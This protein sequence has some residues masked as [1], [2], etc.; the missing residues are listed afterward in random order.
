[1][2]SDENL[3]NDSCLWNFVPSSPVTSSAHSQLLS[4][5]Q[6]LSS[7][8]IQLSSHRLPTP[9]ECIK[10]AEAADS[11][12][13]KTRCEVLEVVASIGLRFTN[14]EIFASAYN[15]IFTE[16]CLHKSGGRCQPCAE[17]FLIDLVKALELNTTGLTLFSKYSPCLSCSLKV[18]N[19]GIREVIFEE[20][21]RDRRGI[22][23][24]VQNGTPTYWFRKRREAILLYRPEYISEMLRT[25]FSSNMHSKHVDFLLDQGISV[26]KSKKRYPPIHLDISSENVDTINN[27]LKTLSG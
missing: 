16:R 17:G 11:Q 8:I 22:A 9:I 23:L 24:L 26:Y 5:N 20:F 15:G 1:M 19:N 18:I 12:L 6:L 2:I 14:V 10:F 7:D 13:G 25:S 3:V 21:Y 27:V 4:F